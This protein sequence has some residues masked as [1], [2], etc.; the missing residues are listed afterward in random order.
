[1]TFRHISEHERRPLN[2]YPTPEELTRAILPR[3]ERFKHGGSI[4]EPCCGD[5]AISK[6]L[7]EA[8]HIVR[9][10]DI[11]NYGFEGCH[12]IENFLDRKTVRKDCKAIVTNPPYDKRGNLT[13]EI[14]RHAIKLME[15]NRGSVFMLLRS[16]WNTASTRRDLYEHPFVGKHNMLWRPYW[17]E[18]RKASPM[19]NYSWFEWDWA[20]LKTEYSI[21]TYLTRSKV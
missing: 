17:T 1:M 10:Y 7:N 16:N 13:V 14:V 15:A 19:H 12:G 11:E 2:F 6:I 21:E 20:S 9:S 5:G 18:E 8:G 3:L 4:L